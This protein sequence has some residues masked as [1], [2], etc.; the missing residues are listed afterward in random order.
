VCNSR[1]KAGA[2][3]V[4]QYGQP[5]KTGQE[6]SDEPYDEDG[7]DDSHPWDPTYMDSA[8]AQEV[9]RNDPDFC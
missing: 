4:N 8:E 6:A 1:I 9:F 5:L 2:P 3:E 7:P